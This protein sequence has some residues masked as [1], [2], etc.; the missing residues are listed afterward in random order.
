MGLGRA[1]P[2][3]TEDLP[4]VPSCI[5]IEITLEKTT[6]TFDPWQKKPPE[7]RKALA[8]SLPRRHRSEDLESLAA[9]EG[10]E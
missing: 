4:G 3:V 8:D 6:A 2:Q 10:R 7:D 5:V 1:T 9:L